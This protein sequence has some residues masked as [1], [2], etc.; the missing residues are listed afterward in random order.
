LLP[1]DAG[2][3]SSIRRQRRAK[4]IADPFRDRT[5]QT[6]QGMGMIVFPLAFISSAYVRALL[7][8]GA[9]LVASVPL[10]VARYRRG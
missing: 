4:L 10:A 3:R 9:I 5:C 6:A 8:A 7:W 2:W 1:F